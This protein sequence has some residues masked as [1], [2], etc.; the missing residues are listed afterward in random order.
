VLL[1]LLASAS[2]SGVGEA[3]TDSLVNLTQDAALAS[4]FAAL[5]AVDAAMDVVARR[6]GEQSA[7][8]RSFV[9]LLVNLTHV[10]SGIATLLQVGRFCSAS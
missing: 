4:R 9:M 1:R 3:A 5:G 6:A 8:A 10:A 2:G 7:L